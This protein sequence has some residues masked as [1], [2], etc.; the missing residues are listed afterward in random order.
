MLIEPGWTTTTSMPKGASSIRS[1]SLRPST[2]NFVAWYQAP[3]GSPNRPPIDEMLTM[4]PLR[5][6]RMDGSTSWVNL[7]SATRL[8]SSW[9]RASSIGTSSRAP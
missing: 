4:R 5:C 9:R 6:S 2:A 8:T 3:I 7:A 1:E